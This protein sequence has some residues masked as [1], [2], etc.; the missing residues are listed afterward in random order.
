MLQISYSFCFC[1]LAD[2]SSPLSTADSAL[3]MIEACKHS[4]T[5]V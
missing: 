3:A 2:V 5:L 1:E 4:H